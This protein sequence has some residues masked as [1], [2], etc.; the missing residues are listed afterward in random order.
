MT[1]LR[2]AL[3]EGRLWEGVDAAFNHMEEGIEAAN[4][5][6]SFAQ[7]TANEAMGLKVR[8]GESVSEALAAAAANGGGAVRLASGRHRIDSE[9]FLGPGVCLVGE[10]SATVLDATSSLH[11]VINTG[12]SAGAS[13]RHLRID[14]NGKADYGLFS[15]P[16]AGNYGDFSPDP[17]F[18][19]SDL[20][21][22]DARI[23]GVYLGA[24][25][26]ATHLQAVRVRRA[27]GWGF[28]L[29]NADSWLV[30]CEAT[31]TGT[32]L[33]PPDSDQKLGMTAGFYVGCANTV[34]RG[35]K[36][37]Y[38]R[39]YGWHVRGTRNRFSDC[40][41]QDTMSHGW[42]IEY[43]R[44]VYTNCIADSSSMWDVGAKVGGADG[45]YIDDVRNSA[46]A[47]LLSFDRK[48]RKPDGTAVAQ[49][50]YGYNVKQWLLDSGQFVAYSGY[51]N[52]SKLVYARP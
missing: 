48:P 28:W 32:W 39:G 36:A 1:D 18:R 41:S 27:G 40:E 37:W 35:C 11:S 29:R 8:E 30:D 2:E 10:G 15:S 50:R 6:A 45:F 44:N 13:V 24:Q 17:C 12:S 33:A 52:V 4:V 49:Q 43:D 21:I 42:R 19:A 20:F 25:A 47:G 5:A 34:M 31:T 51:D 22:D 3:Y 9:L 16:F 7:T 14:C 26:R 23:A 46:F 38:T